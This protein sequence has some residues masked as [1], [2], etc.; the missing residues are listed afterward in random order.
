MIG[1]PLTNALQSVDFNA[2]G[3]LYFKFGLQLSVEPLEVE[4]KSIGSAPD[5]CRDHG[6]PR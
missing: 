4:W 5:F 3:A 6:W 1:T 2:R